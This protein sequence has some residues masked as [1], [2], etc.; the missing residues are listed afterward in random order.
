MW[1]CLQGG[2]AKWGGIP[3]CEWH[4]RG[5]KE[6]ARRP[7]LPS[8]LHLLRYKHE[9]LYT[10][11][12]LLGAAAVTPSCHDG[13]YISR[14]VS[15]REPLLLQA[16]CVRY[17]D[18]VIRKVST[19]GRS[20]QSIRLVIRTGYLYNLQNR[21]RLKGREQVSVAQCTAG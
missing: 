7:H 9:A 4:Q 1:G 11:Q 8:L 19:T 13:L 2:L 21:Q 6:R 15:R 12:G 18:S 16:A 10:H 20:L 5:E 3:K 14:T 17:A